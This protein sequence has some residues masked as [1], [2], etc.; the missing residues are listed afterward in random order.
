MLRIAKEFMIP[1]AITQTQKPWQALP[2]RKND[3]IACRR[4][5]YGSSPGACIA[6]SAGNKGSQYFEKV[7]SETSFLYLRPNIRTW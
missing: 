4:K 7:Q 1:S 2:G 6:A 5:F 3:A